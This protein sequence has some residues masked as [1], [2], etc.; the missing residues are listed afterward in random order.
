MNSPI[1]LEESDF[2]E[3][4]DDVL[5]SIENSLESADAD[6]DSDI[7]SGILTLEFANRSKVIV[8][9]QAPTR[10]IWVAAKSGGFH[11]F[12]DGAVWRD[13]RSNESLESLLSRV[14]SEQSG[15]VMPITL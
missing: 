1:R 3:R 13:T 9:R 4:V 10:E 6:I 8:N 14:I 15:D 7:N 11:F 12:F 2:H 5:T